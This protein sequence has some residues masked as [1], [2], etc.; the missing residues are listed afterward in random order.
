MSKKKMKHNH[1]RC[2]KSLE[3]NASRERIPATFEK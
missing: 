2:G 3:F 1:L